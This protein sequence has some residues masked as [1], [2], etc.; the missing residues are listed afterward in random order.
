[1]IR[2]FVK[3][4][5]AV[6]ALMRAIA[7]ALLVSMTAVILMEVAARY[8]FNSPFDWAGEV[9]RYL[10]IVLTFLGAATAWAGRDHIAI[11]AIFLVVPARAARYL[12]L[13]VDVVVLLL[14]IALVWYGL[15]VSQQGLVRTSISLGIPLGYVFM[16]V[17]FAGAM[18]VL[19]SIRFIGEDLAPKAGGLS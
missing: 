15:A 7:G 8:L 16:V 4:L 9:S 3:V 10:L 11:T 14:G 5:D 1:M 6:T 19:H 12:R 17:P 13:I 2:G 18:I